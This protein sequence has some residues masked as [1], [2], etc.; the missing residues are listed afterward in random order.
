VFKRPFL[1]KLGVKGR[2]PM[3]N[4][5]VLIHYSPK[6]YSELFSSILQLLCGIEIIEPELENNNHHGTN[7]NNDQDADLII[8]SLDEKKRPLLDNLPLKPGKSKV[9]A[10]SPEGNYGLRRMPHT[11]IWEELSPFGLDHLI[12]EV[13]MLGPKTF[14]RPDQQTSQQ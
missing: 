7:G 14:L 11:S 12:R 4:T 2:V 8:L 13:I 9:V 5:R 6:L 3:S 1:Y 10:F